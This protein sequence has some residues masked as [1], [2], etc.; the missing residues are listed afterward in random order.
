MTMFFSTETTA[1]FETVTEIIR[2]YPEWKLNIREGNEMLYYQKA[3]A[4]NKDFQVF[5]NR[6]KNE[7]KNTIF[8]SI[9]DAI[10]RISDEQV[11]IHLSDKLLRQYFMENPTKTKP[12]TVS[13]KGQKRI[14]NMI[15]T[16]NS[17]LGPILTHGCNK[18][19]ERGVID[20][21]DEKW[22]GKPVTSES[23]AGGAAADVLSIGQ[24]MMSFVFIGTGIILS[25]LVLIGEDIFLLVYKRK[26]SNRSREGD[27]RKRVISETC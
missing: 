14:E 11:V 26:Y 3:E 9:D 2:S 24:V 5:W 17:P 21:L 8:S 15:V 25:L 6:V 22:I 16:D 10:R 27:I 12:K 20:I 7:P 23:K 1:T 4:G 19:L 18:L 13:L